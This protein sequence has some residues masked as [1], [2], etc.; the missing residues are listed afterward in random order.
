[1]TGILRGE[2]TSFLGVNHSLSTLDSGNLPG[3]VSYTLCSVLGAEYIGGTL[4]VVEEFSDC[5]AAISW[6]NPSIHFTT[7][8]TTLTQVC[9]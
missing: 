4:E 5:S 8:D 1:M 7:P 3:P 9:I 2:V 6:T